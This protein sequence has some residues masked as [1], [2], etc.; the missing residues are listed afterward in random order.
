MDV[1]VSG[2]NL[3]PGG[4]LF[5]SQHVILKVLQPNF[6]LH[7]YP[8]DSQQIRLKFGSYSQSMNTIN[9]GFKIPPVEYVIEPSD[10][11]VNFQKNPIWY[12]E[13]GDVHAYV[14]I[15][16]Y[17][18]DPKSPQ[19]YQELELVL[20]ITRQADGMM[21]RFALPILMLLFLA[22]LTFWASFDSRVDTTMTILLS[23]SALYV[24]IIGNIPQ[25]GYLTTFD[26]WIFTMFITLVVC[27]C[28][29]QMVLVVQRK[30]NTWPMRTA[31]TRMIELAGR[32][33][34][35]PFTMIMYWQTFVVN[36]S[37]GITAGFYIGT[38][39]IVISL[40]LRE[41]GGVRKALNIAIES[42]SEKIDSGKDH[43]LSKFELGMFN[44][45][46]FGVF[47]R[48]TKPY[49]QRKK[50]RA[51]A[52]LELEMKNQDGTG[53]QN[54]QENIVTN[55]M[56]DFRPDATPEIET[57][58]FREQVGNLVDSDDDSN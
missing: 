39:V 27:V 36:P 14:Y 15:S 55:E 52:K 4:K 46:A 5:W 43:R 38:C 45:F 8:L 19:L 11:E 26:T 2:L 35:V 6:D 49:R 42:V 48:T 31:M 29:H 57:K 30:G 56:H 25:L 24:V 53:R 17:T 32:V 3:K 22:G 21:T 34:L 7:D 20:D 23:V 44:F 50:R 13:E 58:S 51:R 10:G 18:T 12:H 1:A 28:A 16:D 9:L 40:F 33:I 41:I 54:L 47:N 37:S